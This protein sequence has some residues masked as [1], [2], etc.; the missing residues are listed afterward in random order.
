MNCFVK[1]AQKTPK[2]EIRLA[3]ALKK[4]Y[5]DQKYGR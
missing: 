1:K 4:E 3:E 5:L 2:K